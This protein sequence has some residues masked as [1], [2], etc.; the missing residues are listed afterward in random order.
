MAPIRHNGAITTDQ[1]SLL[2]TSASKQDLTESALWLRITILSRVAAEP[3]GPH[4]RELLEITRKEAAEKGWLDGPTRSRDIF[5][6]HHTWLPVR[7]FAVQQGDKLR[8]ID[9]CI[10]RAAR[11]RN[12]AVLNAWCSQ[13]WTTFLGAACTACAWATTRS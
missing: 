1:A 5:A 11:M 3:H 12:T 4:S 9:G 7:R 13:P 10:R 8:P 2:P 6:Q